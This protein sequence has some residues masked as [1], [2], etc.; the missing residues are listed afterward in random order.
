MNDSELIELTG[1]EIDNVS[2]GLPIVPPVVGAIVVAGIV[3]GIYNGYKD[4]S[5]AK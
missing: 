2:G 4:A 1:A 3:V 5:H